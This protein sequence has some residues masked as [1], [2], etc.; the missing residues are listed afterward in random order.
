MAFW[1]CW[2][3]FCFPLASGLLQPTPK[4]F[5]CLA[6]GASMMECFLLLVAGLLKS[7]IVLLVRRAIRRI[8]AINM[9]LFL[10]RVIGSSRN[11]RMS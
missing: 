5:V 6:L 2:G 4:L 8:R 11:H 7:C 1:M 3:C 9:H 10:G